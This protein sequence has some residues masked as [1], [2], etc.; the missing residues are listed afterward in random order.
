MRATLI[1][2]SVAA[3]LGLICSQS[4]SAYP[5]DAAAIQQAASAAAGIEQVQYYDRRTRHGYVKCYRNFVIGHYA[6][7]R[8]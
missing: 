6:C 3:G 2:V 5:V 8:Y 1:A 4:A 7:H